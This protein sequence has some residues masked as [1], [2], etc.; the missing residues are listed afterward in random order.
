MSLI[1]VERILGGATKCWVSAGGYLSKETL[2][3]A[4]VADLPWKASRASLVQ[5]KALWEVEVFELRVFSEK[6]DC[7]LRCSISLMEGTF[8]PFSTTLMV[9]S[10]KMRLP[11]ESASAGLWCTSGS[12]QLLWGGPEFSFVLGSFPGSVGTPTWVSICCSS[13]MVDEGS[14]V[15]DRERLGGREQK[16]DKRSRKERKE[17]WGKKFQ[18]FSFLFLFYSFSFFSFFLF[19]FLFLFF[20]FSFLLYLFTCLLCPFL[21]VFVLSSSPPPTLLYFLSLL[22]SR[23]EL[24]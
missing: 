18:F 17:R 13:L 1:L 16:L 2:T 14:T 5:K 6:P 22:S 11:S 9:S 23:C 10:N 19:S 3:L 24:Y 12:F 15:K 4:T 8:L 20:F 7:W 21:F